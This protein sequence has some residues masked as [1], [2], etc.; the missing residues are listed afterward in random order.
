MHSQPT[1]KIASSL[2]NANPGPRVGQLATWRQRLAPWYLAYLILGLIHSGMLPFLLPLMIVR[3]GHDLGVVAYV[4]GTYNIGLL[5]APLLGM[6][7]ERYRLF[8]S[9]FFGGFI[10]ISSALALLPEASRLV[11]W[12]LLALI[13]GLGVGAVA[14]VAPLF[15]VD[16]APKAEWEPRI[17]WLQSFN[18]G[19]QLAGL[20]L[21][22]VTVAGPLAY[23]FWLASGFA[24]LALLIGRI[25]L[26]T[27]GRRRRIRL[28]RLA[29]SE[30]IGG[31]QSGPAIGGLLQHSHHLYRAA[32][33]RPAARLDSRFA[34]FLLAW[35]LLNLGV[36]PFFAFYPLLMRESYGIAPRVT[37]FFY[38]LAAAIGIG[39]FVMAGRL[40]LYLGPRRVFRA[41]IALRTIGFTVLAVLAVMPV[42]GKPAVAKLAFVLVMLAWPILSVA[43]TGLAAR[44][45]TV[46][47][48]AAMGLLAASSA[49]ATVFGTFLGGP[50][51][52]AFG[53]KVVPLIAVAGL[54]G[55]ELLMTGWKGGAEDHPNRGQTLNGNRPTA[56]VLPSSDV[57]KHVGAA[58]D[59]AATASANSLQDR[60][61]VPGPKAQALRPANSAI[62]DLDHR[63]SPTSNEDGSIVIQRKTRNDQRPSTAAGRA[64]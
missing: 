23:G 43:G 13:S 7:A 22:G 27:D 19:G 45:T 63:A 40:T 26:P 11:S 29:W 41:G 24:A 39:L 47:E 34:R 14:T 52:K 46:G 64:R 59:P 6:F 62:F 42:S 57:A 48:G 4:I 3:S 37:V 55:A 20:L 5:P 36:A 30:L 51:A 53:Y 16:F 1:E 54:T 9:V 33:G 17:G 56:D 50:L 32:F 8:R 12:L 25:G 44:L 28:P 15:V 10:L 49:A 18:G 2:S 35:A 58:V 31:F 61:P 38:A 60:V 21:A